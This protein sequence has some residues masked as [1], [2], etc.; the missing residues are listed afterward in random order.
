[1]Q[2][3]TWLRGCKST[4]LRI[5]DL[6]HHVNF[7][8][9]ILIVPSIIPP[10]IALTVWCNYAGV[11]YEYGEINLQ[12]GL[13]A[14]GEDSGGVAGS[15]LV[16]PSA[17]AGSLRRRRTTVCSFF[18]QTSKQK[19]RHYVK[20]CK[21]RLYS[22]FFFPASSPFAIIIIIVITIIV[23]N[24]IFENISHRRQTAGKKRISD[25]LAARTSKKAGVSY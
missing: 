18:T 4:G 23:V 9:W 25:R 12:G 5:I 8:N 19:K 6:H 24:M 16:P 15:V 17:Q 11:S 22:I 7:W 13:W 1:M 3:V 21:I 20:L 10:V 2:D 14:G